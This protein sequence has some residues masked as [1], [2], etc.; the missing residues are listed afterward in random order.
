MRRRSLLAKNVEGAVARP[1]VPLAH[2]HIRSAQRLRLAAASFE[3]PHH[4]GIRE[5]PRSVHPRAQAVV[6][7]EKHP[8]AGIIQRRACRRVPAGRHAAFHR[9][10]VPPG[11]DHDEIPRAFFKTVKL[12]LFPL[13]QWTQTK[14]ILHCGRPQLPLPHD[15]H[16]SVAVLPQT[17]HKPAIFI[18]ITLAFKTSTIF[19]LLSLRRPSARRSPPISISGRASL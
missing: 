11:A 10:D 4:Y 19:K 9:A 17:A 3:A 6:F 16:V 1:A 13:A 5:A 7:L 18:R 8:D 15:L 2:G 14:P 12:E